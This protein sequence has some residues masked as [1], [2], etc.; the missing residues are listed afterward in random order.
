M[1]IDWLQLF[2]SVF[3]GL[4][5]F[6][7]GMQVMSRGLESAGSERM[8]QLLQSMTNHPVAGVA[9]GLLVTSVIQSS[10]ATTVM[11]VS[12]VHAGFLQLNQAIGVIMGANIG[13]TMTGWIVALLGF[14]IKISSFALPVIGVGVLM[15]FLWP[16]KTRGLWGEIFV[17]FGLLFLG[18][19]F[20]QDAVK[21]LSKSPEIMAMMQH[22]SATKGF[23]SILM[24]V[25]TG[26][27]ATVI[28]QSSSATMALTMTL[29]QQGLI[30]FPTAAALILGENIGTT[31]T[32]NLAAIGTNLAAR[33]AALAHF[34]FNLLGVCWVVLLFS[35]F[36]QFIE[37]LV[38]GQVL[39]VDLAT[40]NLSIAN[41][42]AAYHTVFNV[43][44]TL[45]FLPLIGFLVALVSRILPGKEEPIEQHVMYLDA[46]VL[47]T[48]DL[49][50]TTVRQELHR[51]AEQSLDMFRTVIQLFKQYDQASK[52]LVVR[53]QKGEDV[54]DNLEREIAQYLV[55]VSQ[56]LLS[57]KT[58]QEVASLMNMAHNF[59]K[60]GDHCEA[61]LRFLR[62]R[63]D[64]KVIFSEE[65]AKQILEIAA[66]VEQFLILLCEHIRSSKDIMNEANPLEK[67]IDKMRGDLR[68]EHIQ[69]LVEK[70]CDVSGAL[71]FID[72]LNS[73]EKIGDFAYNIASYI[74][75]A[76]DH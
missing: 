21:P 20:L 43:C 44:N 48:P 27:L 42:M 3:G 65:G 71:I 73:F 34:L 60:I 72:M 68:E 9:T 41:H 18:L 23:W 74:S 35:P 29:A 11:L 55:E 28:I 13:T 76:R 19:M 69:R 25:G 56:N 33:R 31:I 39:S 53:I 6:L 8:R 1:Q 63:Y 40:R 54:I 75:H 2:I 47:A 17:G 58:S 5:V 37:W 7:Y 30:D 46:R 49:A 51:M 16:R 57:A 70:K 50:L 52:P 24:A 62:R 14:S 4:G 59:E 22:Y 15:I 45:L 38:P 26:T 12:L 61:L 10:S 67:A 36:V 32:A 66:L 64:N